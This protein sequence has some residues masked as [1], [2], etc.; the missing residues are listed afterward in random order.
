M[1]DNQVGVR[2]GKKSNNNNNALLFHPLIHNLHVLMRKRCA[3]IISCQD[4]R[5][6]AQ[7]C[8]YCKYGIIFC[9]CCSNIVEC[10]WFR[11]SITA[12]WCFQK[13]SQCTSLSE[14]L[15]KL[16]L[17]VFILF[18]LYLC[19]YNVYLLWLLCISL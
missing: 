14:V 3:I 19:F 12:L 5:I 6:K 11:Y 2:T 16:I 7:K 10:P 18:V 13:K 9:V 17:I 15:C 8:I 1:C 4:F